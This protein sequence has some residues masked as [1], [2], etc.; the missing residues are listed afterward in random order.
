[1]EYSA[2]PFFKDGHAVAPGF[3]SDLEK[4][5][6]DSGSN[7]SREP[8]ALAV[9]TLGSQPAAAYSIFAVS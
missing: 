2:Q 3:D 1:M 7:G 5:D 9:Y 6:S 4:G 8:G